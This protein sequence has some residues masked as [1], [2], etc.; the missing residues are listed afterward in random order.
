M[1]TVDARAH[2]QAL[3]R[4][5]RTFAAAADHYDSPAAGFWR[6]YGEA[7][8]ERANLR[9]GDRVLDLCCGSGESVLAAAKTVGREGKVV[10]ID[11]AAPMLDLAAEKVRNSG[12]DNVQLIHGDAT[13]LDFLDR[14][15]D[16]VICVFGIFFPLDRVAFGQEMWRVVA[17]GG[18]LAMTT[19][20]PDV[21]EPG[22]SIFWDSVRDER[23][24]LYKN[25]TP[26]DDITSSG[27][28]SQ[29]LEEC[30]ISEASIEAVSGEYPLN[31]SSDFW[32]IVLGSGYRS[33]VDSLSDDARSRLR[34]RILRR[35]EVRNVTSIKTNVLFVTAQRKS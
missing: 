27:A 29:L 10:G 8:V 12:L 31:A 3:E 11:I 24:D 20:G 28:L 7:T 35:V 16:A 15:F 6:H 2:A 5:S 19:W 17:P 14:S 25:F 18:A 34:A 22:N 32:E 13:N 33:T 1:T 9:P 30:G 4:V 21:F 23:P 26:W